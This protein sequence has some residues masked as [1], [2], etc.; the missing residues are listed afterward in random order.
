MF[1]G[2]LTE[3]EHKVRLTH[4]KIVMK[5]T[6]LHLSHRLYDKLIFV[7]E[8]GQINQLFIDCIKFEHRKIQYHLV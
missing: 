4:R 1:G 6:N 5:A 7:E 8:R 2:S 3:I